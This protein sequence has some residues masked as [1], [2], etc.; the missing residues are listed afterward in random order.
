MSEE[1]S[2]SRLG[3]LISTEEGRK[4][5]RYLIDKRLKEVLYKQ[6]KYGFYSTENI[7][8]IEKEILDLTER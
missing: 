7:K 4:K 8:E 1:I 5:Y 2:I 3:H 6:E